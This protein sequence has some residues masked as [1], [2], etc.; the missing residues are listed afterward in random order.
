MRLRGLTGRHD[1]EHWSS[2]C[3]DWLE[4]RDD[5]DPARIGVMAWSLGGYHALRAAAFEKRF[6]L[7]VAWG[8]NYNWGELQTTRPR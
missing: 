7:C 8:A 4:N 1:G 6:S 3:V 2:A 5:V